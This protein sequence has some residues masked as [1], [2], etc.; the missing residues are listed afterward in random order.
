MTIDQLGIGPTFSRHASIRLQDKVDANGKVMD[1]DQKPLRKE[2]KKMVLVRVLF[3]RLRT[4]IVPFIRPVAADQKLFGQQFRPI[5]VSDTACN[6]QP[7]TLR[8]S[9]RP[10]SRG[11]LWCSQYG[12]LRLEIAFAAT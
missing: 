7:N 12:F 9:N 8:C 3:L 6:E 4:P 10:A 5:P 2:P 11:A 1:L